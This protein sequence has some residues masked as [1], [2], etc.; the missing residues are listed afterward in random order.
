MEPF[1]LGLLAEIGMG[2]VGEL[3]AAAAGAIWLLGD[4]GNWSI[5]FGVVIT[6]L[7]LNP[8]TAELVVPA[9]NAFV[10]ATAGLIIGGEVVKDIKKN[11][12][13]CA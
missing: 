1:C 5:M 12:R 4:D 11:T 8:V 7:V 10:P 3:T 9:S 2:I 6:A 13:R